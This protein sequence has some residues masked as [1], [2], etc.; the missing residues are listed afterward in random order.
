MEE[1]LKKLISFPTVTGDAFAMHQ[2][3]NYV[4][5][6]V[7]H[8]GMHVEWFESNGFESIVATTKQG[9][10]TPKVMLAAHADVVPAEDDQF[11]LRQKDG[12]Y[13][14]RGVLDMKGALATYLQIIDDIKDT[15]SDYDIALVVTADEEVG[16]ADGM[17]KLIQE[18][19]LPEVCILPDGGENWQVQTIAKGI[20][21][22]D[23]IA[24]GTPAH[25][26]RPWLGDNAITK[27]FAPLDELR[28]LFPKEMTLET[29]TLS[30]TRLQA[31]EALTQ[32]PESASMTLDIRTSNAAEH[33]RIYD[34]LLSVCDKY[35]LNYS[36]HTAGLP[37]AFELDHPLIAPFVRH[38]ETTTGVKVVGSVTPA[39]SDARY[40]APYGIPC[41]SFYP[42]GGDH[43][44]PAEWVTV[45]ALEQMRVIIADYLDE[46]ARNA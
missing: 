1:I 41:I 46:M 5:S 23:I 16:G 31:G 6:F 17:G 15:V 35:H 19:Y 40:F 39:T 12:T 25:S 22:V 24:E 21:S 2:L 18:G 44:S 9:N 36:F 32:I 45:H 14:G 13:Y 8:R 4:A 26:S 43:H 10:K 28:A 42:E 11:E 38:I 29:N 3:L 30:I 33:Q 7:S 20:W 34:A 37:C 27:L